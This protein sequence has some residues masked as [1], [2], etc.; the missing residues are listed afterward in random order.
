V[1]RRAAVGMLIVTTVSLVAQQ[2]YTPLRQSQDSRRRG[3]GIR[4]ARSSGCG[5]VLSRYLVMVCWAVK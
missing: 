5:E 4:D 1:R 2:C 3:Q